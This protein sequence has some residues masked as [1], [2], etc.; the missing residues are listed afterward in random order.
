MFK[1]FL[2]VMFLF[3][4]NGNVTYRAANVV[5]HNDLQCM[6]MLREWQEDLKEDKKLKKAVQVPV[7]VEFND[8]RSL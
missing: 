5:V 3:L 1:L 4:P 8:S 2:P 7:C 6:A